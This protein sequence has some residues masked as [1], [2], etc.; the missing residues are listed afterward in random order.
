MKQVEFNNKLNPLISIGFNLL[1]H[2]DRTISLNENHCFLT[3]FLTYHLVVY[4]LVHIVFSWWCIML[5]S[6]SY[7]NYIYISIYVNKKVISVVHSVIES[8]LTPMSHT[9]SYSLREIFNVCTMHLLRILL[10]VV[11]STTR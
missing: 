7:V 4:S 3:F 10:R 1:A 8:I 6:Y 9:K 2:R 11:H 5:L